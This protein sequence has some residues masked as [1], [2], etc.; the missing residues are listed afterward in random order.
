MGERVATPP[1]S[2]G[3]LRQGGD[4]KRSFQIAAGS[5]NEVKAALDVAER[6]GWI[7]AS[8][9]LRAYVERLLAMLWRMTHPRQ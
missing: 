9:A 8:D 7:K 3:R 6:W 2:E 4:Q 1:S 5:C